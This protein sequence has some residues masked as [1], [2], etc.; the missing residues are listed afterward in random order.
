MG[1]ISAIQWTDATWNPFHGCKK[2]SEGCKYCYMY[3]DKERY[4]QDPTKVIRSKANFDAPLKWKEPRLIFTCSWSDWFIEEADAWRPELWEIIKKTPQHTY[5]ILTKRP[6]RIKD[7]LPPDWGTGYP[8][9]WIGVSVENQDAADLRI[10]LLIEI[11]AAV[12][13][14]SMEPL[15]GEVTF[16]S[17][18]LM[19]KVWNYGIWED[20]EDVEILDLNGKIDW[21]ILGGESGNDTGKYQYRPAQTGWFADIIDLCEQ[22]DIPVFMKQLGTAIAKRLKLSDRHGGD[23]E[24]YPIDLEPLKVR[25]FPKPKLHKPEYEGVD[26]GPCESCGI[27]MPENLLIYDEKTK[28]SLC[29]KC[30]EREDKNV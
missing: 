6:E 18:A 28:L 24:E 4:K 11:P 8:N 19:G 5:Q 13:F 25:Q 10:P 20:N 17:N 16:F 22:Y 9:V 7:N 27:G 14:L 29:S 2:V 1:E 12:R 26:I 21:I 15:I 3:R 23:L 30:K